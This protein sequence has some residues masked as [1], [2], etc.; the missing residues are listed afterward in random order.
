MRS[1]AGSPRSVQSSQYN[2]RFTSIAPQAAVYASAMNSR[3]A[4]SRPAI[5]APPPASL[6]AA[7]GGLAGADIPVRYRP[8]RDSRP[9]SAMPTCQQDPP[10]ND[11]PSQARRPAQPET[12]LGEP[13]PTHLPPQPRVRAGGRRGAADPRHRRRLVLL[14]RPPRLGRQGGRSVDLE[15]R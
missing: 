1:V 8:P 13:R 10:P 14:Q 15:G 4:R 2:P 9:P 12:V 5:S 11:P 7:V 6:G 3:S